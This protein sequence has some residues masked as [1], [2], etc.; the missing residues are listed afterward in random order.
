MSL[1]Q[2]RK[3]EVFF[4]RGGGVLFHIFY[5]WSCMS[6]LGGWGVDPDGPRKS[7]FPWTI[8]GPIIGWRKRTFRVFSGNAEKNSFWLKINLKNT[9]FEHFCQK[10]S[11][12]VVYSVFATFVHQKK[13][14]SFTAKWL[15]SKDHDP[16]SKVLFSKW[17]PMLEKFLASGRRTQFW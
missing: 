2:K 12:L 5:H 11:I 9:I 4:W 6:W 17:P 1:A 8:L 13:G 3:Q 14:H 10:N 15:R 7:S 16:P